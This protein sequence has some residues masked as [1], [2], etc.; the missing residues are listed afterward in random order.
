M[1]DISSLQV[2]PSAQCFLS[3]QKPVLTAHWNKIS[4]IWSS[5]HATSFT[6]AKNSPCLV[7]SDRYAS[8][9][10]WFGF[11]PEYCN[12]LYVNVIIIPWNQRKWTLNGG[13]FPLFPHSRIVAHV[14]RA[15]FSLFFVSTLQFQ[16]F[17][18][19]G[20]AE[21]LVFRMYSQELQKWTGASTLDYHLGKVCGKNYLDDESLLNKI[22]GLKNILGEKKR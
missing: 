19:W 14:H 7:S 2:I 5:F 8:L 4:C 11:L 13:L 10:H 9:D 1:C 6:K 15:L 20:I 17:F 3:I 12:Q 16:N 18:W 21:I 22:C